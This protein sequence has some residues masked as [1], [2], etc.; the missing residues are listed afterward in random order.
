MGKP[1]AEASCSCCE[2]ATAWGPGTTGVI[3]GFRSFKF[4]VAVGPS[5]GEP[6]RAPPGSQWLP[7]SRGSWPCGSVA[8]RFTQQLPCDGSPPVIALTF[9][10]YEKPVPLDQG[11]ALSS[12]AQAAVANTTDGVAETAEPAAAFGPGVQGGS[13]PAGWVSPEHALLGPWG[14]TSCC[15]LT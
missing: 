14:A 7:Q 9:P 13:V 6:V 15:V 1:T 10:F 11:P 5:W 12:C 8:P 3:S 4:R 2:Q